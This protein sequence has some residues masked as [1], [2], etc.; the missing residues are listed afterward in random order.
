MGEGM[1]KVEEPVTI[2]EHGPTHDSVT[3]HPAFAQIGASR[4]SGDAHLYDSDFT[5]QHY[6]TITI[7]RSQLH[8][9]L[10][11]DW[12][13]GRGELIQVAL[14]EAQWATFVSSPNQ[15]SGV[16]CTLTH[17]IGESIPELPKPQN[18]SH[19]FKREMHETIM[20]IQRDLSALAE[21]MSGALSKT[22]V[23][24]I[25][26]NIEMQAHRLSNS[27]GFVAEQ[28]DEHIEKTVEKAKIEISAYATNAIQRAGLEAIAGKSEFLKLES[29][30]Q[31]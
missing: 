7:R 26:K 16:P 19:Q 2:E 23:D 14:S 4:V 20:E 10:S 15:G 30:S 3:T 13:F 31:S 18:A 8:R 21:G 28:F 6:M 9:G 22:K 5:H 11:R 24:A 27:T 1:R 17:L 12:H 25:R 29:D